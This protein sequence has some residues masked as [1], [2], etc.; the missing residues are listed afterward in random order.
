MEDNHRWTGMGIWV[1]LEDYL[2]EHAGQVWIRGC[3]SL[4]IW[5][6]EL[7]THRFSGGLCPHGLDGLVERPRC[8]I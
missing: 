7:V 8:W 4:W 3:G 1:V 2:A 6:G 5:A